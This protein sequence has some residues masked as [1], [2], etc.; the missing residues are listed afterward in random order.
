MIRPT[1]TLLYGTSRLDPEALIAKLDGP[2]EKDRLFLRQLKS[3]AKV[4]GVDDAALAAMWLIETANG[5][6]VRWNNDL[7]PGGIGIPADS[8]VQPFKIGD[9]DEA[10]RIFVQCVYALVKR[11][12]HPGVPIPPNA[13]KWFDGVW[14]PKVQSPRMPNVTTINDLNL[15][16]TSADGDSQAT[17][18]WNPAHVTTLIARGNQFMP[19]LPDQDEFTS[20][21]DHPPEVVPMP[22]TKLVFHRAPVPESLQLHD[23]VSNGPNTAFDRLGVRRNLGSFTHRMVGSL[24]GT[25][26]YFQGEAKNRSLTDFGIGGTWDGANDGVIYQWVPKGLD[27]APWASGPAND[28]EG[29]GIAFVQALGVN[30]VNRDMR[31]IELSDGGNY[32]APWGPVAQKLQYREYIALMVYL[33]DDAEVPWDSYPVNPEVGVVTDLEHWEI[34][35]K[36]CPF[37]PVRNLVN[38]RQADIRAGLKM[39]QTGVG[40]TPDPIPAEP[41]VI[42][43]YS[44]SLDQNFLRERWGEPRRVYVNGTAAVD[45]ETGETKTYPWNPKWTPCSAWIH[46]CK[47]HNAFPSP[48]DW[49][50]IPNA[51]KDKGD[52]T[53]MITF[54]NGW[55]LLHFNDARGW[56]WAGD[57]DGDV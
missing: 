29:D 33:F 21:V 50:S 12:A 44:A 42:Q 20:P 2:D 5:T 17:W 19:G 27:I 23:I 52:P 53:S 55:V 56:R 36:D 24:L 1:D 18:A 30:A 43:P 4:A 48:G 9:S 7:N 54:E 14:L 13:Q 45:K 40:T 6:S 28:L 3:W 22:T 8:T 32:L 11:K 38:Q 51:D 25:H 10:A 46:R 35:P 37:A 39:Y 47:R 57:E 41:P 49:E 26:G 15:H 16:Y 31:A 34:G